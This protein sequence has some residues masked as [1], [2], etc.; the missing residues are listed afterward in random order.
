EPRSVAVFPWH[1]LVP[2]LAPSQ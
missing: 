2:F 1:S